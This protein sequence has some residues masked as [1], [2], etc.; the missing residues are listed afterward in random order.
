[1]TMMNRRTFLGTTV[2]GL[3]AAELSTTVSWAMPAEHKLKTVG[4]QLYTVRKDMKSDF[5]GTI[6]KVAQIGY[7][8]VEFAG[9]DDK[10]PKEIADLLKTNGLTSPSCHVDYDIVEN[11]WT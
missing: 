6:A 1:M 9:Y 8:E 2:T 10:S 11:K 3:A 7:K 4:L 5:A